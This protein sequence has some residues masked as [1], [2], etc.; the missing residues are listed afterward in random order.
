MLHAAE[1]HLPQSLIVLRS[2]K[3]CVRGI[4]PERIQLGSA[5]INTE[6][7]CVLAKSAVLSKLAKILAIQAHS[8]N[9]VR[10][11]FFV[12]GHKPG[13]LICQTVAEDLPQKGHES[14]GARKG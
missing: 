7:L 1:I 6:L 2:R 3:L 8:L 10:G 11:G 13:V 12:F 5:L 4:L 9:D 14:K